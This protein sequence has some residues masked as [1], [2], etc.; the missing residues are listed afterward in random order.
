MNKYLY[1]DSEGRVCRIDGDTGAMIPVEWNQPDVGAARKRYDMAMAELGELRPYM[2]LFGPGAVE[3]IAI[4]M[5]IPEN[6]KKRLVNCYVADL[7]GA[8]FLTEGDMPKPD[9]PNDLVHKIAH[10]LWSW[11]GSGEFTVSFS[12]RLIAMVEDGLKADRE[13]IIKMILDEAETYL[14]P[15]PKAMAEALVDKIRAKYPKP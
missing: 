4:D 11:E 7:P 6:T 15:Q 8:T 14:E 1:V 13:A 5:D 10:E 9:H 12:K 3:K 2:S